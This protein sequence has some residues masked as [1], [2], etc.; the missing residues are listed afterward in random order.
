VVISVYVGWRGGSARRRQ[1]NACP[2]SV[3]S[4]HP[5]PLSLCLKSHSAG[6]GRNYSIT[7]V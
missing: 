6:P 4:R 3:E 7:D 5:S 2:R 1:S